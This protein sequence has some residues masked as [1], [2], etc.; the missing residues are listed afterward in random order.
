MH[1]YKNTGIL[2]A[3]SSL[4]FLIINKPIPTTMF[5]KRNLVKLR[6]NGQDRTP[7]CTQCKTKGHYR[8]DC[9][10]LKNQ[11]WTEPAMDWAQ[12]METN[13]AAHPQGGEQQPT[14]DTAHPQGGEQQPTVDT[15]HPQGGEQQQPVESNKKTTTSLGGKQQKSVNT[16]TASK[17]V[18]PNASQEKQQN[19]TENTTA[20]SQASNPGQEWQEIKYKNKPVRRNRQ[21]NTAD[22]TEIMGEIFTPQEPSKYAIKRNKKAMMALG[23]SPEYH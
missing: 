11:S 23:R 21:S 16:K 18:K 14:V 22:L 19:Q 7:F 1:R 10:E 6:H 20:S 3:V 4:A 8:L 12:E 9:P 5:V 17:N 15:A 2:N 13:D